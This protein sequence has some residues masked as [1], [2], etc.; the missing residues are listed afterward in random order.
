MT[1]TRLLTLIAVLVVGVGAGWG[2]CTLLPGIARPPEA[3]VFPGRVACPDHDPFQAWVG[4]DSGT[5]SVVRLAGQTTLIPE[6]H[7]CQRLIDQKHEF[8][9]LAGIWVPG[10]LH[11]VEDSL[12]EANAVP[13][14][15]IHAWDGP[16]APLGIEQGWNCL[17]LFY[18][19]TTGR[20][21]DARMVPVEKEAQC[22]GTMPAARLP[23]GTDLSVAKY[24]FPGFGVEDYPSVG[25]WD[26]ERGIPVNF[27]GLACSRSWCEI[28]SRKFPHT[29]S[30]GYSI[31]A[32]APERERRVYQVKGWYD[33]QPLAHDAGGVLKPLPFQGTLIPDPALDVLVK[34]DFRG[35]WTRAGTATLEAPSPDYE[36]KLGVTAG[37]P[38]QG[39]QGYGLTEIALCWEGYDGTSKCPGVPDIVRTSCKWDPVSDKNNQ[40]YQ[41]VRAR[42]R[43]DRYLCVTRHD[44]S[45]MVSDHIPGTAR[46]SW[47]ENDETQWWRCDQGC[48][49]ARP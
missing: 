23:R 8:G 2:L 47:R 14:A 31:P 49:T 25:R 40:W 46:W 48:C 10:Y 38:P 13:V 12:A 26:R 21:F 27:I 3:A 11:T 35:H 19:N 24:R 9:A 43:P 32:T 36:T 39:D 33:E 5:I 22:S 20:S 42:G 4:G 28:Y 41:Q 34:D 45:T 15:V 18:R 37:K 6:F 17:Y 44:H 29:S 7:D 16:Y 1:A 30:P